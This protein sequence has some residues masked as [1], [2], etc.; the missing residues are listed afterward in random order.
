MVEQPTLHAS[1]WV[2]GPFNQFNQQYTKYKITLTERRKSKQ[3]RI[4]KTQSKICTLHPA[5]ARS[6]VKPQLRN[7]GILGC[8]TPHLRGCDRDHGDIA[9]DLRERRCSYFE[10]SLHQYHYLSC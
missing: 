3:R 5:H 2:P 8:T 9:G 10:K 4:F 7:D 1:R 6:E